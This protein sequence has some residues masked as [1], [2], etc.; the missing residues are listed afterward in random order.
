MLSISLCVLRRRQRWKKRRSHSSMPPVLRKKQEIN[1]P[2]ASDY[3][4]VVYGVFHHQVQSPSNEDNYN[5]R[6][7]YHPKIV[8]LGGDEQL[9]AIYA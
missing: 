1:L 7:A 4:N 5:D 8:F 6:T 2:M 9:T 3:D